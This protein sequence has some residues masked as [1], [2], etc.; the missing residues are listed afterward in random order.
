MQTFNSLPVGTHFMSSGKEFVKVDSTTARP[1]GTHHY[2]AWN[3]AV[4]VERKV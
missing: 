4:L 1:I 2:V 3:I